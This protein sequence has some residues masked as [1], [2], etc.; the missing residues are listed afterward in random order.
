MN[1]GQSKE[2]FPAKEGHR[3]HTDTEQLYTV[4]NLKQQMKANVSRRDLKESS[5]KAHRKSENALE[6]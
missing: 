3:H 1:L 6:R 4:E 5:A 2:N